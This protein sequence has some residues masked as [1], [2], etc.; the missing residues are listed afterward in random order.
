MSLRQSMPLKSFHIS[1]ETATSMVGIAQD[2]TLGHEDLSIIHSDTRMSRLHGRMWASNHGYGKLNQMHKVVAIL[3][4]VSIY[5]A[6][7]YSARMLWIHKTWKV[8]WVYRLLEEW[9]VLRLG[10]AFND[11]MSFTSWKKINIPSCLDDSTR[12][13]CRCHVLE[14]FDC[15]SKSSVHEAMPTRHRHMIKTSAFSGV[16]YHCKTANDYAIWNINIIS[17]QTQDLKMRFI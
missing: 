6:L 2:L 9:F 7:V 15:I 3:R 11:F 13:Y 16:I 4:F 5:F 1:M 14:A 10:F 17:R 12:T 8:H